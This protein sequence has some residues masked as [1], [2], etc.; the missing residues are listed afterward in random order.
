MAVTVVLT[1]DVDSDRA[2]ADE[3]TSLTWT[4]IAWIPALKEVFDR[5]LAR[6]TWFVRAD[7]QLMDVYGTAAHLLL[8]HETLWSD[9]VGTGDELGWHPHIYGWSRQ[10]ACYVPEL[11]P[12]SFVDKLN[13][14]HSD[15]ASHGYGFASVRIGEGYH[16][17]ATM[18]AVE[19]LGLMVDSTAIPGRKR[20]DGSRVFDWAP[21]PNHPYHP[22]RA[23]Y[24]VAGTDY[25]EL[26]EVP[27]TTAPIKVTYDPGPMYRYLNPSFHQRIF[28]AALDRHVS[29][30]EA[31]RTGEHVITVILHPEEVVPREREHPLYSFSLPEVQRNLRYLFTR[32]EELGLEHRCLRMRDVPKRVQ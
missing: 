32:L 20:D 22:S 13:A 29:D 10:T 31:L 27:M 9:V 16:C 3:R 26:L 4:S 7:N 2:A 8:T 18:Q 15:L 24:R 14:A 19:E 25:R 5:F 1:V 11:D 6:V 17:N 23:D 21:T 30:G 12:S 28:R